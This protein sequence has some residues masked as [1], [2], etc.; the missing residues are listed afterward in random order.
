[1]YLGWFL[2]C[3]H[4]I[5]QYQGHNNIYIYIKI[6]TLNKKELVVEREESWVKR[7]SQIYFFRWGLS[8]VESLVGVCLAGGK[9][10]LKENKNRNLLPWRSLSES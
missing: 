7:V 1:L 2:V 9:E 10:D 5:I 4:D 6:P 3:F 8:L